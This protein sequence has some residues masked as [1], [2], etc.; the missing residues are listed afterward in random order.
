MNEQQQHLIIPPPEKIFMVTLQYR[1]YV[2][3]RDDFD[4]EDIGRSIAEDERPVVEVEE[5]RSNVLGW[6]LHACVYHEEQND[7]D[8]TVHEC[9]PNG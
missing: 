3:A 5:V 8:I 4:A 7:R 1:G 6:P 9:F 2:V